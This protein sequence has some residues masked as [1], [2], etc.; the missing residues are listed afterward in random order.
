M[1]WSGAGS[2]ADKDREDTGPVFE[3]LMST[4]I[5]TNTTCLVTVDFQGSEIHF[6]IGVHHDP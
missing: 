2:W 4:I 1:L 6:D 5:E 3:E